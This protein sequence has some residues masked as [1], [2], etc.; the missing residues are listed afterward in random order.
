V[1]SARV[2]DAAVSCSIV[3][4]GRFS[5]AAA[6]VMCPLC[7]RTDALAR[8]K[9]VA[10]AASSVQSLPALPPPTSS[11]KR[12]LFLAPSFVFRRFSSDRPSTRPLA[13]ATSRRFSRIAVDGF[14][15][16]ANALPRSRQPV[17]SGSVSR[18]SPSQV[19][20]DFVSQVQRR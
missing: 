6:V 2:P 8:N 19:S 17:D 13:T 20:A 14:W 10:I 7:A 9:V 12:L 16:R 1:T 18:A 11:R 4:D 15:H 5:A 3:I